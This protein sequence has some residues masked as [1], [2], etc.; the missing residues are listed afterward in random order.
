MG[1]FMK[2]I[3]T[4]VSF[5]LIIAF[6]RSTIGYVKYR[7]QLRREI[8]QHLKKK[9]T[10]YCYRCKEEVTEEYNFCSRGHDR[11]SARNTPY[12]QYSREERKK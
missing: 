8:K 11:N 7:F 5:L 12:F 2:Q 3:I 6:I 4:F 1:E 9:P 10:W